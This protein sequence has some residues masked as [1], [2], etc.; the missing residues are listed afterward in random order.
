MKTFVEKSAKIGFYP[1]YKFMETELMLRCNVLRVYAL[2]FSFTSTGKGV[3]YGSKKYLADS[4]SISDRT[5]YRALKYL[6]MRGLIENAVTD[7]GK[8]GIRCTSVHE[9]ERESKECAAGVAGARSR[10][11][12]GNSGAIFTEEQKTKAL[13]NLVRKKYGNLPEN[14]HLAARAAVR[15][16][17]ERKAKHREAEEAFARIKR[18]VLERSE[19]GFAMK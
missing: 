2:L 13:D 11:S 4:L 15:D 17:I 9:E 1:I 5:V 10:E 18:E 14:L 8:S 19:A 12:A 6:F 7:D 3:Y 16:N